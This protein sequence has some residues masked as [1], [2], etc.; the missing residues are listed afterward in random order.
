M[1]AYNPEYFHADSEVVPNEESGFIEIPTEKILDTPYSWSL[2]EADLQKSLKT[3]STFGPKRSAVKCGDG[4]GFVSDVILLTFDWTPKSTEL[5]EKAIFKV[6]TSNSVAGIRKTLKQTG[7]VEEMLLERAAQIHNNEYFIYANAAETWNFP[8]DIGFPKFYCGREFDKVEQKAGYFI[9][10]YVPKVIF[11]QYY[12]NLPIRAVGQ[13]VEVL[14]KMTAH[15]ISNPKIVEHLKN[16][17]SQGVEE[18]LRELIRLR[19]VCRSNLENMAEKFPQLA[20]AAKTLEPLVPISGDFQK[21]KAECGK[22]CK[23]ELLA[24]FDYHLGNLLWIHDDAGDLAPHAI[25][26]WQTSH[27]NNPLIDLVRILMTSL[28]KTDFSNSLYDLLDLY[29][30]TL[31]K[32]SKKSIPWSDFENFVK[33]FEH[34]FPLVATRMATFFA[35]ENFVERIVGRV[36]ESERLLA[37]RCCHQKMESAIEFAAQCVQ[38]WKMN[39]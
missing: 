23:A 25:I 9:A 21:L 10:E 31:I 27:I 30:Q 8:T 22:Y 20:K 38:K 11:V 17:T 16:S 28:S 34:V 33:C 7:D 3:E 29:Y 32:N 15:V 39:F 1:P 12:H 35:L 18:Y 5:P 14:A 13:A 19:H 36:P 24:H 4:G 2:V 37:A 26:D 6:T